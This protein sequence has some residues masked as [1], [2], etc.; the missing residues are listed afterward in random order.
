MPGCKYR[1]QKAMD[2]IMDLNSAEQFETNLPLGST[3]FVATGNTGQS[4]SLQDLE[5]GMQHKNMSQDVERP[6]RLNG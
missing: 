2:K 5:V 4:P 6:A 3:V 1:Q